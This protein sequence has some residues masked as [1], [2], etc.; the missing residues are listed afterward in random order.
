MERAGSGSD[1]KLEPIIIYGKNTSYTT[2]IPSMAPNHASDDFE[3]MEF[4]LSMSKSKSKFKS[5]P[6][7]DLIGR[8]FR[9][10]SWNT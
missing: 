5:D 7:Y 8:S 4:H 9:P 10:T 3:G 6:A 1:L 2:V